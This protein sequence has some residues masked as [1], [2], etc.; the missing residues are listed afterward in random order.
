[1]LLPAAKLNETAE[2][3]LLKPEASC[4]RSAFK[5][6]RRFAA[7]Q[8][9]GCYSCSAAEPQDEEEDEEEEQEDDNNNDQV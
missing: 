8:C 9:G 7:D 1:M 3:L 5:P 4:S 2:V 6:V